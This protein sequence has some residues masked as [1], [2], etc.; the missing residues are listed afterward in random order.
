MLRPLTQDDVDSAVHS[1]SSLSLDVELIGAQQFERFA[2]EVIKRV[3]LDRGKR[4]GLFMIGGIL[5]V[6]MTK[7]AVKR[8]PLLGAPIGAFVNVL[9]PT[10]LLGPAVGVAGALYL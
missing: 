9:V 1:D 10:T 4:L 5:V 6:H 7:N 3:A 8:I 2:R